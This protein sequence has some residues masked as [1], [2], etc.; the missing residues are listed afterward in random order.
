MDHRSVLKVVALGA[1]FGLIAALMIGQA[2]AEVCIASQYGVGDGHQ[3]SKVACRGLG[4][5]NTY[6]SKPYTIAYRDLASRSPKMALKKPGRGCGDFVTITNLSNG[7]SMRA[8]ITDAGPFVRDRCVDVG[9][10][11]ANALGMGGLAK[12]RVE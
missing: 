5:F 8:M 4:P 9:R 12:V 11:G 7:R 2:S 3:G 6:A 10:A 1:A